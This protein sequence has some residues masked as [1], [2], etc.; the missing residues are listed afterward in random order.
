M[1]KWTLAIL[2]S[3]PWQTLLQKTSAKKQARADKHLSQIGRV[4]G[5]GHPLGSTDDFHIDTTA[6]Y[7][8]GF[9]EEVGE[10]GGR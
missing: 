7:L 8:F 6:D 10:E 2:M 5:G 9:K 4:L 3:L 1:V